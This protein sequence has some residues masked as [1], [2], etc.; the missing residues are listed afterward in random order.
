MLF[1]PNS[2]FDQKIFY[3]FEQSKA[4][5]RVSMHWMHWVHFVQ[6]DLLLLHVQWQTVKECCAPCACVDTFNLQMQVSSMLQEAGKSGFIAKG[7]CDVCHSFT[8]VSVSCKQK[9]QQPNKV[10][11]H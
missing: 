1:R 5:S 4:L 6:H 10:G 8:W 9:F 11:D 2:N 3:F 7:C